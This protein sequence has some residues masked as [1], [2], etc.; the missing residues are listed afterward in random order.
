[1]DVSWA[2]SPPARPPTVPTDTINPLHYYDNV[3]HT[4][5]ICSDFHFHF[6]DV[7]NDKKLRNSYLFLFLELGA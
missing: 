7:L 3:G 4:S 2:A 5:A 6:D 1:M